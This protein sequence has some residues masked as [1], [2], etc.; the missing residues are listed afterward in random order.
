MSPTLQAC[1]PYLSQHG[2]G[3]QLYLSLNE[4]SLRTTTQR[5][6]QLYSV[7]A[8]DLQEKRKRK[9]INYNTSWRSQKGSKQLPRRAW[10]VLADRHLSNKPV[11]QN[12]PLSHYFLVEPREMWSHLIVAKIRKTIA[13][14]QLQNA[15]GE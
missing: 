14:C 7:A 12:L 3:T 9:D 1:L 4:L 5:M 2:L 11:E 10:I 13:I 6:H 15:K 8:V